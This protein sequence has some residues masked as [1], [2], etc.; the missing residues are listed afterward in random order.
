MGD[1]SAVVY[2]TD[3]ESYG[4]KRKMSQTIFQCFLCVYTM[5]PRIIPYSQYRLSRCWRWKLAVEA[6]GG[7][8]R[9]KLA[10]GCLTKISPNLLTYFGALPIGPSLYFTQMQ[11]VWLTSNI[12]AAFFFQIFERSSF[13]VLFRNIPKSKSFFAKSWLDASFLI[14]EKI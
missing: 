7:S 9:W 5:K 14:S 4:S 1:D 11:I 8:W 3:S 6:G 12:V 2:F 13:H 10:V